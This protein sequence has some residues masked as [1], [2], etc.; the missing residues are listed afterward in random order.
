MTRSV[1]LFMAYTLNSY[2]NYG[3]L[4]ETSNTV[5]SKN[6]NGEN[7]LFQKDLKTAAREFIVSVN[8]EQSKSQISEENFVAFFKKFLIKDM[9][10]E[11]QIRDLYKAI[12]INTSP[13]S[14]GLDIN[15]VAAFIYSLDYFDEKIDGKINQKNVG[16]LFGVLQR[17]YQK[18][19]QK[20]ISILGKR[21]GVLQ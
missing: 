17:N 21:A 9:Y 10:V 5:Y 8:E 6:A 7:S 18:E 2:Y 13:N 3:K 11:S 12:N 15:E 16:D 20:Y 4:D 14:Q 1:D 19:L